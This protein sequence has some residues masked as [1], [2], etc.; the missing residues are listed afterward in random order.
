M[1]DLMKNLLLFL[2]FLLV[3]TV[4]TY[5]QVTNLKVNGSSSS[6]TIASGDLFGWS[7][8]VP[9]PGDTTLVIIWVD[10]DQNGILNPAVDVVWTFFN[11]VD[12]GQ[13]TQGGPP[14]MDGL[15]NGHVSFQQNLGLAPAHYIMVF[16]NHHNLQ[17]I[18]GT[19][20][21]MASPTFTISGTVTVPAG[22]NKANIM[23]SL[24]GN[25]N[26][27]SKGFWNALTDAN[28]N[29]S[30][31]MNSD[32]SGNPWY[33]HTNNNIIFGSAIVAPDGYPITLNP[34][35]PTYTGNN[36]TVTAASATISGTVRDEFGNG[37]ITEVQANTQT[38]TINRR[39]Q[40]DTAGAFKIGLL[41][42]ELPNSNIFCGSSFTSNN[43]YDT[44]WVTGFFGVTSIKS[45]DAITHDITIFKTNSTISGRVTLNGNSPNM[46]LQLICMNTDTGF[47]FVNSDYN[48]NFI[49]HVT[50]KIF[51][52]QLGSNSLPPGY[53][54]SSIQV[55]PGESNVI[56]NI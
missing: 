30:I 43:Q 26:G 35:T 47:V 5:S 45:G 31:K 37:A 32:T 48:G 7:Y 10:T 55:H 17:S 54:G 23:L 28:G 42:S 46:N 33:V 40:T 22:I 14:D 1:G 41:S 50:N 51:N 13:N 16:E 34:G 36:F 38:N 11:Q 20:T 19:V 56:Y 18:A 25:G 6:F 2:V 4:T 49:A 15:A 12:G 21:N 39:V 8:D 44:N 53:E 27:G 24:E 52:Y 29:F 9:T 3:L